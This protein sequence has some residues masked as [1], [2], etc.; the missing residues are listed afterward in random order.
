MDPCIAATNG[1]TVLGSCGGSGISGAKFVGVGEMIAATAFTSFTGTSASGLALSAN[2]SLPIVI[3]EGRTSVCECN[4]ENP[5]QE[6][7][8]MA[9]S[10][11]AAN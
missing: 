7:S 5:R 1:F 9:S 4:L 10:K 3:D 8:I 2:C 11:Y 6:K